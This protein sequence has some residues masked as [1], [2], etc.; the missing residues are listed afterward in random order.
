MIEFKLLD[1]FLGAFAPFL[2]L[3][4]SIGMKT[5]FVTG[6]S[7]GL[8]R[9]FVEV[10]LDRGYRVFAGVRDLTV[11]DLKSD[12]LQ[13]LPIELGNQTAL[14]ESLNKL[15]EQTNC[16][17][18]LINCGAVQRN[19][20]ELGGADATC[21]L[22]KLSSGALLKMFEINSVSPLIILQELLPLMNVDPS[23]CINISSARGSLYTDETENSSGN[24]GYRAS[25]TALSMLTR[26]SVFDL[27][28]NIRTFSVHPG[29]VRTDMNPTGNISPKESA[30]KI[31]AIT[32]NWNDEL[33]GK[34]LRN[35]GTVWKLDGI[36]TRS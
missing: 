34:F 8:G 25:K 7:R 30:E 28:K 14:L 2:F 9:G 27:P 19:S 17:D 15:K 10:L 24:Y 35:D 36:D 5:A 13:L 3:L 20:P 6:A 26:A 12:A 4:D 16:I 22:G 1:Y 31:L 23:Y 33:Q 18:F 29:L 32:Q 11:L 21:K